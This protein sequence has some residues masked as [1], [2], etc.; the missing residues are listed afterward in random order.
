MQIGQRISH[1][2]IEE[3]I[4]EGGF[5]DVFRA[6]DVVSGMEVAIKCSRPSGAARLPDHQ[7]R[8]L[9]EVSCAS[10]VRHPNIVQV[11]DY[12]ALADGTLYL[13]MEYV[14][15]TNLEVLIKRDA[16]FS[17]VYAS[18]MILQVLGALSEAHSHAIIHRDLKPANI[19]LVGQGGLGTDAVKLLDFG[20]AKAFDGTQPDLTRQ[21]FQNGV[22][23]GTPHY[24]PPEQFTGKNLGPHSD[25]YA[26][27]LVYFELLTGKQAC[28]GNV[29]SEVIQKQIKVFPEIPPPFNQGPVFDVFRMALAKD[30]SMRYASAREMY[31]DIQAIIYKKS[32]FLPLYEKAAATIRAKLPDPPSSRVSSEALEQATS[33][34]DLPAALPQEDLSAMNTIIFDGVDMEAS[35]TDDASALDEFDELDEFGEAAPTDDMSRVSE[36]VTLPQR[37]RHGVMYS[38]EMQIATQAVRIPARDPMDL[39]SA[40]TMMVGP[41]VAGMQEALQT[42][43][44]V[45][46]EL[47]PVFHQQHT[48]FLVSRQRRP[49]N[50][51]VSTTLGW[52]RGWSNLWNRLMLSRPMIWFFSTRFHQL[53]SQFRRRLRRA[54]DELYEWH[55]AALVAC[56]CLLIVIFTVVMVILIVV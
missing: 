21:N 27:G 53:I 30:I 48:Q 38:A 14:C 9:R 46:E 23:F 45:E 28:T 54:I 12:G 17:F 39:S 37:A 42:H 44:G 43:P 41:G 8:F 6:R 52:S 19:M 15:G 16:P 35:P 33:I 10:K 40:N 26:I 3:K 55:F 5:G 51:L 7:Q 34:V 25:L 56:I 20:I 18:T 32:P 22:G 29:L 50:K 13:V 11:F 36:S 31:S 49:G 24:M 4:G 2:V 47:P 1:Y